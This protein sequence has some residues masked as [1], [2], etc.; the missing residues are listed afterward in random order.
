MAGPEV[1]VAHAD[2]ARFVAQVLVAHGM[3]APDAAIVADALVWANLRGKDG[4]GVVRLPRY[5]ELIQ[6]G[7]LDPGARP[8][9]ALET[10]AMFV[11]D[12]KRAAGAVAMTRAVDD[13]CRRAKAGGACFG[14]VRETTH[15][16]A[17]GRFAYQAAETGC[18]VLMA[19][20]GPPFMAYHGTTVPSLSTSPLAIGVPGDAE[21]VVLDLATS[22]ASIGRIR[23]M[24]ASGRSLPDGW[25]LVD[26]GT[27]AGGTGSRIV[28]L[29]MAGAKGA[30]LSLM[31]ELLTSVLGGAPILSTHLGPEHRTRHLQNA[32]VLA[33][34]VAA[35]RTASGFRHDVGELTAI[36]KALPVREGFDEVRL[37]GEGSAAVERLRR[38]KG[39]PLLPSTW[40]ALRSLGAAHSVDLPRI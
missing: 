7:D 22:V 10:A 39:I 38:Q 4:H 36:I 2:L 31:F 24:L 8:E 26:E 30:G 9:I 13:A 29:P 34:D 14:L 37:P 33:L 15:V 20:T 23:Q 1:L 32:F 35:F 27:D 16:G 6:V 18:A 5:V 3:A 21:P 19:A 40:E 25:A 28:P 17:I 12:A 11:L